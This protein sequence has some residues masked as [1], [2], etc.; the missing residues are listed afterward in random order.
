M[1][2]SNRIRTA[3]EYAGLTQKELADRVGI[4][5]TAVHKLECG[6]SKSSRRTVAISVACGVDPV[7]LETG[8]GEM[9][10]GVT[11]TSPATYEQKLKCEPPSSMPSYPVISTGIAEQSQPYYNTMPQQQQGVMGNVPPLPSPLDSKLGSANNMR[12]SLP[13]GN[14]NSDGSMMAGNGGDRVPLLSWVEVGAWNETV[15]FFRMRE[16]DVWVSLGLRANKDMFALQVVGDAM[17]PE[18]CEGDILLVNPGVPADANKFVIAR[19]PGHGE[20]SFKQLVSDGGRRFLK[21][22]NPRY[23][24]LEVTQDTAIYGVVVGKY[25]EYS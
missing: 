24:I 25:K 11:I 15:D 20:A 13:Y 21:P 19:L 4:S 14:D 7:W 17:E 22:L 18:F 8:R 5:Q 23:P 6:R 9:A 2:L 10:P 16:S 1:T 3:R 12:V